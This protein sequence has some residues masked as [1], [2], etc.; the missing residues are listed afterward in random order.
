L[1]DDQVHRDSFCCLDKKVF[2]QCQIFDLVAR[3]FDGGLAVGVAIN[4]FTESTQKVLGEWDDSGC[5]VEPAYQCVYLLVGA[6]LVPQE[7]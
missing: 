1:D 2:P 7:T 5:V 3:E 4:S 6:A